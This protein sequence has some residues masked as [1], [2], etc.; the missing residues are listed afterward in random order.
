MVPYETPREIIALNILL[1]IEFKY[2][3]YRN[4]KDILAAIHIIFFLE[5]VIK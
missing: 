5:G 4:S 3:T 1:N 2:F